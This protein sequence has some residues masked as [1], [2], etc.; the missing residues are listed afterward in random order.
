MLP[1]D[2]LVPLANRLAESLC[3]ETGLAAFR[4]MVQLQNLDSERQPGSTTN[5]DAKPATS[6]VTRVGIWE[7]QENNGKNSFVRKKAADVWHLWADVPEIP[8]KGVKQRVVLIG[9]SV[10]RGFFYDPYVTPASLLQEML[11]TAAPADDIEVIDLARTDIQLKPLLELTESAVA[12]E[13]DAFVIFGGN[14]WHPISRLAPHH[15]REIAEM[16]RSSGSWKEVKIYLEQR[17]REQVQFLLAGLGRLSKQHGIP[18]LV[19]I[20]EFNLVDWIN[21]CDG[22]ALLNNADILQWLKLR[23]EAEQALSE[24]SFEQA[25]RMAQDLIDLDGGT[26][27]VGFNIQ[28]RAKWDSGVKSE[29][30]PLLENARDAG[31]SLTKPGPPRCF[32]TIQEVMRQEA[33]QY[34]IRLVDLPR[35]FEEY[36]EGDMPGRR[37][38]LD[39]CHLTLEGMRVAMAS[40]AEALLPMLSR[41]DRGWRSFMATEFPVTDKVMA[42][43]SF[44]AAVHNA[45]WGNG[46]EVIRFHLTSAIERYPSIATLMR[47]Y[48]DFHLR[49]CPSPLCS[50]FEQMARNEGFSLVARLFRSPRI[51]KNINLKL[52][53]EI[54]DVLRPSQPDIH[55]YVQSLMIAEHAGVTVHSN[56]F[57]K[58]Y[59]GT[60]SDQ[61]GDH[62]RYAYYRLCR[63]DSKFVFVCDEPEDIE[64]RITSRTSGG[65]TGEEIVV[66]VNDVPVHSFDA[67]TRWQSAIF[68]VQKNVLAKGINEL[69]IVW[70]ENSWA[71][72]DRADRIAKALEVGRIPEV[73]PVYGEVHTLLVSSLRAALAAEAGTT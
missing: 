71:Y 18:I 62:D 73:G 13:P 47:M 21:D 52:V 37:L 2:K 63:R 57:Q 17:L 30:R 50:A 42:E 53:K 48:L 26:T 1:S 34:D 58:V 7:R 32:A 59:F 40:A 33:S 69:E 19:M 65:G 28:W 60:A 64:V 49:S 54:V 68:T 16:I 29:L 36:L 9:E 8:S 55:Q 11:R 25:S 46:S 23:Q 5:N 70:P 67:T 45:N 66:R 38:F 56:L 44:L 24:G 27:P 10:A 4:L 15:L 35:R 39:Y 72:S 3:S 22:P 20:P 41:P 61:S 51:W 31:I 12:L 14:N 43:A 6:Q